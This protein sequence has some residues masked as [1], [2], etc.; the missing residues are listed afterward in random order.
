MRDMTVS[1]EMSDRGEWRNGGRRHAALTPSELGI[2]QEVE[3]NFQ[4]HPI[5][6][7]VRIACSAFVN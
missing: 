7:K 2:R 3:E 5:V 4:I 6:L 1:D